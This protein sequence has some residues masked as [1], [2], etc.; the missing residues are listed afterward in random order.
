MK[1]Q[2]RK[3]ASICALAAIGLLAGTAVVAPAAYSY[4]PLGSNLF[5]I[6][7]DEKNQA[8]NKYNSIV[9]PKAA[10]TVTGRLIAGHEK[11]LGDPVG[12]T[13]PIYKS[14]D[15]GDTW[16]AFT[17]VEAPAFM[18]EQ[19]KYSGE[20]TAEQKAELTKYTSTWT[21]PYL[22][23]LPEDVGDLREGDILLAVLV[24]G[25]DIWFRDQKAANS[26]WQANSDGDRKDLAI[27]LYSSSRASDGEDWNFVRI[28]D[29]G[30]WQADYGNKF[31]S[32]NTFRQ[33]DPVWE[34]FILAYEGQLIVYY[35]DEKDYTSFDPETGVPVLR[36]DWETYQVP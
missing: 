35:T 18:V 26:Q 29:I 3:R 23:V 14:D 11:S 20:L 16:S 28:V 9:Y 6:S 17:E 30:G 24:S 1:T 27:A 2:M 21:N 15:F 36:A 22:Y 13:L 7:N 10:S 33:Q 12:Q 4:D 31:S 5:E 32:E 19:G 34:P 25:D 8:Q